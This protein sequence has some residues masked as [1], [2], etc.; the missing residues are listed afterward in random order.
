MQTEPTP[1]PEIIQWATPTPY[2]TQPNQPGEMSVQGVSAQSVTYGSLNL[3]AAFD[4]EN[5]YQLAEDVVNQYNWIDS[6]GAISLLFL[7]MTMFV[8]VKSI[9]RS[10]KT[11]KE[12]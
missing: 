4:T 12:M 2:W 7:A 11:I 1:T 6:T 3:D 10:V 5:A 8:A 9:F